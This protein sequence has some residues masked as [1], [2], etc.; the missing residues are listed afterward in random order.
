MLNDNGILEYILQDE[1]FEGVI[2]MLEYDQEYPSLKASFRQFFR[3]ISRFRQVVEIKDPSIRNKIHQTYRLQY[4]KEVVLARLLDDPTFGILNGFIFF[5]QVDIIGHI[6]NNDSLLV[7]LFSVFST[8]RSGPSSSSQTDDG[9][10]QR[11]RDTVLFLHQLMLMGKSIQMPTRLALYRNLLDRCLLDV[12][13]WA[14]RRSEAP[15]VHAAAEM[16]TL[17]SEHDVVC[18]RGYIVRDVEA[19]RGRT[20]ITEIIALFR[21]SPNLGL[22]SQ[23]TDTMRT[24]LEPPAEPDA[25][26]SQF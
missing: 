22:L 23:L 26:V 4:L 17:A 11:R 3:E 10:D 20:L 8:D 21:S 12:V 24:L 16:L 7:E 2:G 6:Q 15:I 18:V 1:V 9:N 14:F 5:N 19:T 25:A 13:E